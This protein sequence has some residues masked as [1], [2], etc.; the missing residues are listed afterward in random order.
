M[1]NQNISFL[2]ILL[3]V[4]LL[5]SNPSWGQD[6]LVCE[7]IMPPN[8]NDSLP[9]HICEY[10]LYSFYLGMP[11]EKLQKALHQRYKKQFLQFE[12]RVDFTFTFIFKNMPTPPYLSD[13]M[14]QKTASRN[15]ETLVAYNHDSIPQNFL[16]NIKAFLQEQPFKIYYHNTDTLKYII[17]E[18]IYKP[19]DWTTFMCGMN[20]FGEMMSSKRFPSDKPVQCDY[21]SYSIMMSI[22]KKEDDYSIFLLYFQPD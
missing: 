19:S 2:V 3:F 20:E 11:E 14:L 5:K 10:S 13:S 21:Y 9:K 1:K 12:T 18:T 6:D 17:Q 15:I 4:T 7:V 16:S 8:L 22:V